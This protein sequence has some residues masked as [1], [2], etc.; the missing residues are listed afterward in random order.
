LGWGWGWTECVDW[1]TL[2]IRL[3]WEMTWLRLLN[4]LLNW[5]LNDGSWCFW[6]RKLN[7]L[8]DTLWFDSSLR[9]FNL[10]SNFRK[11]SWLPF[12]SNTS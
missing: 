2:A 4:E 11:R 1:D 7:F 5:L 6:L 9:D 3:S 12:G 10:R 8:A